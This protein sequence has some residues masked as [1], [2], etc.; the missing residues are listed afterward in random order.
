MLSSLIIKILEYNFDIED[1][2]ISKNLQKDF[3]AFNS[4]V[5]AIWEPQL[6]KI[7]IRRDQLKTVK[8]YSQALGSKL[9]Q[10]IE[11]CDDLTMKFEQIIINKLGSL[12]QFIINNSENN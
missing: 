12:I 7:I 6:Q 2:W 11:E 3:K 10:T 5:V 9:I 4:N 1:I 8:E